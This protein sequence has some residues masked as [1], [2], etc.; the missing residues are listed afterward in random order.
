MPLATRPL[1][2]FIIFASSLLIARVQAKVHHH[3]WEISYQFKSPDCLKK[4]AVTINGQT[5]GPTIY[6]TEGDTVVIEVKNSLLTE[7]VAIHW[8]GIRQIGTPWMDG[9]EGVTQCPILPGDT[10]VYRF[11]VDQAGTYIYHAH[12][13]MQRSAGLNGMIVVKVPDGFKEPFTYDREHSIL[14]NDWWHNST[15]EQAAGLALP[16]K[17][18]TWV[19][20]PHSLLI[21]GRG[22][23]NC[24]LN[25]GGTCNSTNPECAPY[26]LTVVPGKT[27]RLRIASVTSLSALNFEIEGHS[28]TVVEADSHYVD[29]F[30]V[31]NLNIYSGE[32][33]SVILKADQDPNRNYWLASN[34]VSRKPGTPTG[35][36]ILH[37]YGVPR[38]RL[39]TNVPPMGTLWNDTMYRFNQSVAIHAHS[40]FIES[41]PSK[42]DRVIN[43]LNTQNRVNGVM[44]WSVN[45]VSFDLPRTPYL[46]ALKN[47]LHH[48]FEQRPPPDTYDVKT[49]DI[50]TA[51][52]NPN[53]TRS[54]SIYKL[55]FGSVVDVILQNANTLTAN[56]SETHP[57][58]LHGHDF[59][60]LGYGLGKFDPESDPKRYNLKN[61]ILKNTVVVHPLGWTAIRFKA[62]NPGV[63][64]F[65]CH[66]QSHFFM[67]MR[68]VFEE[69]VEKL[70]Q[71]PKFIMGCGESKFEN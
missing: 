41:P 55:E 7:N 31:K 34:V 56:N 58:H 44:R 43:L 9:T 33:Y 59:W 12:Y 37:Y 40:S 61:P 53:A 65:H 8:H 70:G 47:Y 32:T 21:N 57:W 25:V 68:I 24:S 46:I 13:G 6:A 10:F 18:F 48:V 45:N 69:G 4:L 30:V 26:T 28:L 11:L 29:P 16:G 66:I 50:F 49:Y 71:L 42:S 62:N 2:F 52:I 39:P 19:G 17:Q 1:L 38:G 14:L 64:A 36:G 60:V 15:Y 23:F 27:Y 63:W 3:K 5:P 35:T 54:N 20:E 22:K 51:P 67:G